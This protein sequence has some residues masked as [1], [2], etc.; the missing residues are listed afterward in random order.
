MF[1][2]TTILIGLLGVLSMSCMKQQKNESYLL[3]GSY[4]EATD[5]GLSLYRFDMDRGTVAF[6]KNISGI[7]D[8][9]YQTFA[10]KGTLLYSVSETEGADAKVCAYTF[11]KVRGDFSFLNEQKTKGGAP[12]HIWV[13]SRQR[14]AVTANYQGGNISAFPI[15][16]DGS[17][18]EADIFSFEGGNP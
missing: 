9:S 7:V 11:D 6:I 13:D 2:V 8:P 10:K 18:M 5:A 16:E 15:A 12:C 3:V 1:K 17:L 4:S 14:L